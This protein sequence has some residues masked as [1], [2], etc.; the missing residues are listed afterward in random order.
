MKRLTVCADDFGNSP[1]TSAV[2][3]KL[4]GAGRI[5]ATSCMAISPGWPDD[6]LLLEP[7]R[8]RAAIGLHLTLTSAAPLTAMPCYAPTRMM[9]GID[10]VAWNRRLPLDEIATEIAAQ[11]ERFEAIAGSPPD[12]V[13]GHQHVHHLPTIRGLVLAETR[14]RAPR[15]WLRDCG[16]SWRGLLSRPFRAKAFASALRGR[17]F[18]AAARRAGLATNDGFAGHYDFGE[19][20]A[21]LLPAFL[22]VA[23]DHHLVMVHPGSDELAGDPI[24][25]ARVREAAVLRGIDIAGLAIAHGLELNRP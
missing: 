9:P 11:F 3:A 19:R 20:F 18:G 16:D 15:A 8:E 13:D 17:G 14:R 6:W 2:I 12:F 10:A 1:G 25:A 5:N 4:I 7:L 22:S 24:G 23:G 21:A